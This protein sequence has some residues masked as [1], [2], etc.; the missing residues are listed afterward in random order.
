VKFKLSYEAKTFLPNEIKASIDKWQDVLC[1]YSSERDKTFI[2]VSEL[3]REITMWFVNNATEIGEPCIETGC[4][5]R[6]SACADNKRNCV[7][8][9]L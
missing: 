4:A 9:S 7:L 8:K 3:Q 1:Q 6:N 2:F 5:R